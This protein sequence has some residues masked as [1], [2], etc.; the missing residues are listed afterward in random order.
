M[1]IDN[2]TNEI[3]DVC[4]GHLYKKEKNKWLLTDN[5]LYKGLLTPTNNI[6]NNGDYFVLYVQ[7]DNHILVKDI[8]QKK[9]NKWVI[10]NIGLYYVDI[11]DDKQGRNGDILVVKS[12]IDIKSYLKLPQTPSNEESVIWYENGVWF[13][14]ENNQAFVIKR[15]IKDSDSKNKIIHSMLLSNKRYT[16]SCKQSSIKPSLNFGYN[17]VGNSNF[18]NDISLPNRK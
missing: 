6:G 7:N 18:W 15:E 16:T 13:V 11:I 1:R 4:D 3:T 17:T 14:G 8:Y 12:I 5:R 9:D 2:I 10:N